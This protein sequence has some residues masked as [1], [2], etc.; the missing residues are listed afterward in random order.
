MYKEFIVAA[1]IRKKVMEK[2]LETIKLIVFIGRVV[3]SG[4]RIIVEPPLSTKLLILMIRVDLQ[5]LGPHI[6][7]A[8][9][10]TPITILHMYLGVAP[11]FSE[12]NTRYHPSITI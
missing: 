3:L 2:Y 8:Q 9:K 6:I 10:A 1:Q 12:D 5:E 7:V 4:N 11:N